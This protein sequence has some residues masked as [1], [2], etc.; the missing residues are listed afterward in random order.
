MLWLQEL[1]SLYRQKLYDGL[2][3]LKVSDFADVVLEEEGDYDLRES[4]V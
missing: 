1:Q 2:M 4:L 3:Q